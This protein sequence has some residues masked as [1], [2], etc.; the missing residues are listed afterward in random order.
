[1]AY[2]SLI[3]VAKHFGEV[4]AVAGVSLEI[5]KGEFFSLLG[6]SGCGKTT[7][8]RMVAGFVRPSSGHIVIGGDEMTYLPP[9]RRGIGIVFQNYAIFPHMSVY[10]NIAFGL[11]LR[12]LD[13]AEIDRRVRASL[14]QVGLAGFAGRYQREMSGGQQ[15]RVALARVLVTEPHILLLDEPLS[16]LDKKLREEMKYWIKDLQHQLG[17]TTIYVTHD[18]GEAL[19]MSDRIAVMNDGQVQQIGSPTEIYERPATRFVTGFIGES[20]I[21]DG[22]VRAIDGERLHLAVDGFEVTAPARDG[23]T[24]GQQVAVVVR[25]EHLLLGDEAERTGYNRLRARILDETYQGSLIRYDLDVQGTR[26]VA[27]SHNRIDRSIYPVDS[28]ITIGW[29]PDGTAVLTD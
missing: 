19:T 28:E 5:E 24:E 1:M 10:D 6:P 25:P 23:V 3:E 13:K 29:N 4:V 21:L 17:I 27:E 8:L 2:V 15:Q 14:D 12:K 26:L 16:A 9:E 11:K 20:N 18:Q 7:M 22:R